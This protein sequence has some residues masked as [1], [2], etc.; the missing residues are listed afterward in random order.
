VVDRNDLRLFA[1]RQD[2]LLAQVK[3]TTLSRIGLFFR[4]FEQRE[5]IG[6]VAPSVRVIV[7]DLD[8][9]RAA[10]FFGDLDRHAG[11]VLVPRVLK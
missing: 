9:V 2:E 1:K 4:G 8:A 5:R 7:D 3:A 11:H 6:Y 10:L